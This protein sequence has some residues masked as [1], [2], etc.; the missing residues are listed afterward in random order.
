MASWN[1]PLS[2]NYHFDVTILSL[3]NQAFPANGIHPVKRRKNRPPL[4]TGGI[5]PKI[6]LVSHDRHPVQSSQ[7]SMRSVFIRQRPRAMAP[8]TQA[9]NGNDAPRE[10]FDASAIVRGLRPGSRP[11][12]NTSAIVTLLLSCP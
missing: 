3:R 2:Q 6:R 7:L 4:E 9:S 10:G 5:A 8:V 11:A 12:V 1:Y